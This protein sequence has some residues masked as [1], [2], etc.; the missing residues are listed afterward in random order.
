MNTK[1]DI[2]IGLQVEDVRYEGIVVGEVII[3]TWAKS[4][5]IKWLHHVMALDSLAP[6][7]LSS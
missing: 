4:V 3:E 6:S 2:Y 7:S 5:T 1:S